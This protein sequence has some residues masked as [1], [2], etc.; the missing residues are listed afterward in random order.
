MNKKNKIYG[1]NEINHNSSANYNNPHLP[2]H[3]RYHLLPNPRLPSETYR[4]EMMKSVLSF[5]SSFMPP[6]LI[7]AKKYSLRNIGCSPPREPK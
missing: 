2:V 5:S 3:E 4:R 1:S 7:P 6:D